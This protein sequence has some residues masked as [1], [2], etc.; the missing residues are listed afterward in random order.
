MATLSDKIILFTGGILALYSRWPDGS[1]IHILSLL[2]AIIFICLCSYCNLDCQRLGLLPVPSRFLLAAMWVSLAGL[3]LVHPAF[4]CFLPLLFYELAI[5]FQHMG[6]LAACLLPFLSFRDV[7]GHSLSAALLLFLLAWLFAGKTARLLELEREFRLLRDSSTEY[8]LLLQQKNKDLIEK[9]NHEIHIATLKERNRIAREIHDNV[10]HML[11]RSILQ[12]GALAAINQQETMRQPLMDLKD[13]LSLAM[14][15]IRESVHGLHDDSIDLE[16]AIS[17]LV[18]GLSGYQAILTYDM[19][20]FVPAPVKYCFISIVKEA[21]SNTA[22]HSNA[23]QISIVLREH[24]SL[25]QLMVK[26]N[27]TGASLSSGSIGAQDNAGRVSGT[28]WEGVPALGIAEPNSPGM[29]IANMQ[30]RV[31]NLNGILS[32]STEDGFQI[33]VSLPRNGT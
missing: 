11:S 20:P 4:G 7:P 27:G 24:P 26:D 29:G 16:S 18:S 13:T 5:S 9:Q 14:T 1:L 22:R 32:I 19:G 6:I 28:G 30:E 25:Y 8:Q 12:S 3:S 17:D 21:V 15:S 23:T 10:G 33:F 31:K 2:A